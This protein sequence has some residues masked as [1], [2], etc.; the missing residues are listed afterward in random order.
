MKGF[1]KYTPFGRVTQ[2][3][4]RRWP[5]NLIEKALDYLREFGAWDEFELQEWA[6][7]EDLEHNIA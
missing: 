3:K 7:T 2:L 6:D 4:D 1:E 5:D